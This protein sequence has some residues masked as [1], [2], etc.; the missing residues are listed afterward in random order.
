MPAGGI[1]IK[2]CG[3]LA[4][5][6]IVVPGQCRALVGVNR[7]D[8]FTFEYRRLSPEGVDLIRALLGINFVWD[9]HAI[10][11]G[12]GRVTTLL[13]LQK[14]LQCLGNMVYLLG[15]N[16]MLHG[17]GAKGHV[18]AAFLEEFGSTYA[19]C[20]RHHR[21]RLAVLDLYG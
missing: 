12:T 8:L 9:L 19:Q 21:V 13:V 7:Q 15:A 20:Q 5:K 1:D 4:E 3:K 17:V 14:S 10:S 2:D 11:S 6:L 18:I 16:G